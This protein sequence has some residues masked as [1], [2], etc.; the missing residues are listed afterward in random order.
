MLLRAM[1]EIGVDPGATVVVGDTAYDIEM[2]RRAGTRAVGVAWGYHACDELE[3]AG[4]DRIV[5]S[6]DELADCI[7]S[8]L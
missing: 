3:A 4:A 8:L 7:L 2:A 5:A 6:C 1:A